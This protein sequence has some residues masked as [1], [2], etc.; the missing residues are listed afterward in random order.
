MTAKDATFSIVG[1][2]VR[3]VDGADKVTG[4]AK[5]TGDLLV[6]GLIEGKFLR[7]PYAHARIVSIDTSEAEAMAGVVAVLTRKDFT[8]ISPYIGRG[9]N[10]DHPIIASS[11]QFSPGNRWPRWPPSIARPPRRQW[12]KFMSSMKN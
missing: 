9:K 8:D 4:K 1:T 6:P 11:A 3:R 5:Y 12:A 10:K 2:S 7:S